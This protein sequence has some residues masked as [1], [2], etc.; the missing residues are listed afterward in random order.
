[1]AKKRAGWERMLYR[2][3]AGSTASTSVDDNVV[4]INIDTGPEFNEHTDRGAGT[5]LP[6][7][8]E[9]PVALAINNLTFSMI[10][11]DSDANMAAFLVA[12]RTG[13]AIAIKIVRYSGGET[14]FDGDCY[15]EDSSP[16]GLKDGMV[17][18]FTGHPTDDEGRDW[19]VGT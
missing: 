4:D 9:Q 2:G 16:G 13:A 6:K 1:M 7:K 15:L 17:V 3:T 5:N 8:T 18:E 14:E 19:T 12:S 10:Y 11:K